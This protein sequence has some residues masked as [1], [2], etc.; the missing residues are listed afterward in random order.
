MDRGR[1]R[2]DFSVRVVIGRISLA[3]ASRGSRRHG[4]ARC[5]WID[6][7]KRG[8]RRKQPSNAPV[9]MPA[10]AR[11]RA[12]RLENSCAKKST[13]SAKANMAPA[14]PSRRLRSASRRRVVPACR[15]GHRKRDGLQQERASR[16][17]VIIA[18]DSIV[19]RSRRPRARAPCRGRSNVS[20]TVPRRAGHWRVTQSSRRAADRGPNGVWRR[21]ARHARGDRTASERLQ[22]S[23][24]RCNALSICVASSLD[25]STKRTA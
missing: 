1:A 22:A 8:C 11:R 24:R 13:T 9:E 21:N 19:R 16:P 3:D 15:S 20:D 25:T 23:L 5:R 17:C 14:R 12:R 4:L 6:W 7:R 10:R 18:R 2:R